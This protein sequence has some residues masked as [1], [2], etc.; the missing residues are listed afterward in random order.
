MKTAKQSVTMS[1]LF[2]TIALIVLGGL[3]LYLR[4]TK[5]E[6]FLAR[7]GMIG[8]VVLLLLFNVYNLFQPAPDPHTA[9]AD[10]AIPALAIY[11]VFAGI[12]FWLDSKRAPSSA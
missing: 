7:Y 4:A 2:W 11:F 3:W 6:T 5:G 12:A 9:V 8:Y 10:L 1:L